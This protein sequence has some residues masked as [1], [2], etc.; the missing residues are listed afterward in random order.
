MKH[1]FTS[2]VLLISTFLGAQAPL[3]LTP[4]PTSTQEKCYAGILHQQ[5]MA[6]NPD[7]ALKM[8]Q[9]KQAVQ[10]MSGSFLPKS[11]AAYVIPVVFHVIHLGEAIGTGSNV[12]DEVIAHAL[13]KVN[14]NYRNMNNQGGSDTQ[15]EFALAV[16]DP[17]GNC[18]NGI[19]RTDYSSSSSY[20]N[21]GVKLDG[22]QG[23]T[24]TQLKAIIKWD[25]TKYY[26]IYIITEIDNNNGGAGTQGYAYMAGAH[27]STDDG[28][29]FMASN[30]KEDDNKTLT[31]ELGHALNL[32][33][34]FEGDGSGNTCPPSNPALGDECADTPPHKRSQSDCVTTGTNACDGGSPNSKFVHNYLNYSSD[35]CMNQ[36]TNDQGSRMR[37]ACA[38]TRKSFFYTSNLALV[39]PTAPV[40]DILLPQDIYCSGTVSLLDNSSCVPN[41][42]TGLTSFSGYTFNWTIKNGATTL[43]SALQN[44]T[45]NPTVA[46]WY[47][48][49]LTVTGPNGSDTKTI[50]DAF[51]YAG[52]SITTCTPSFANA[53]AN[54]GINTSNVT[55][56]TIN[57][58]TSNALSGTYENFVCSKNTVVEAGN[59]Y[60]IS[61]TINSYVY[62]S[63]F[64][65]YID[66]NNNGTYESTEVV[67]SGN[68][69][70]TSNPASKIVTGNV[71]IPGTAVKNTMLRMRVITEVQT[72]PSEAKANCGT[73]TSGK[74][75]VGDVE[76]YAVL[77]KD[78]C[79]YSTVTTQ[80]TN[81][82]ICLNAS[83]TFTTASTAATSYQWEVSTNNGSTW[84]SVT[85]NANYS[86]ATTQTLN[87]NNV[88][89]TFNKNRYRLKLTNACGDTFSNSGILTVSSGATITQQP[90]NA[91]ICKAASNVFKVTA[92]EATTY[93]WQYSN[94]GT[95]WSDLTNAAPYSGVTTASMTVTNAPLALNDT[96]YRC[97]ISSDCGSP[98]N[99]NAVTLTVKDTPAV[100]LNSF[101]DVCKDDAKFTLSGGSP[102]GGT[103]SGAGVTSNMFNPSVAGNGTHTITYKVTQNGCSGTATK[104]IVV[105]PCLDVEDIYGNN[106]TIYPNP[107][108]AIIYLKGDVENY[109]NASLIDIQGRLITT[110]NLK[111][112]TQFDLSNFKNGTYFIKIIGKDNS[113]VTKIELIR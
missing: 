67:L 2:I 40:A 86:G 27:G 90:T 51:Y 23:I 108:N 1:I 75:N 28:A 38:V 96:K 31:H 93:K 5:M 91:S 74:I 109:E 8:N 77:I 73:G 63:Y 100:S 94:D 107:T 50:N 85:N 81:K 92:T 60:P 6:S 30:I 103:Y 42:Y 89:S 9:F 25:R 101:N 49:T 4:L 62:T 32:L 72:A 87:V 64:K 98:V 17:N 34:T 59:T 37:T 61:V 68:V 13:K 39:A 105:N 22:A 44:P 55:F 41:T 52:S 26:N 36:F 58:S 102:T 33:H 45:F 47:N 104:S 83:T 53:P 106:L 11:S 95:T 24:D 78:A 65:A 16:R 48:V 70:S 97:V 56:N 111:E 35:V 7:Y 71:T 66:W 57:S 46:G 12:S 110:W 3:N 10:S 113:V 21:Y 29:V 43:T 82:S 15:I 99:T 20:K 84:T 14:E 18:T 79:P 112:T 54:Y 88:P 76:D 69:A 80:P 19:T